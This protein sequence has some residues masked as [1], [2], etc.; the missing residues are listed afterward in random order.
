MMRRLGPLFVVLVAACS[1][2]DPVAPSNEPQA[3]AIVQGNLQIGLYGTTLPVPAKVVVSGASGPLANYPVTFA[4]ESGGSVLVGAST[5]TDANG[6]ATLA[7]WTLGPAPGPNAVRASA[8]TKSVM[9]NATAVTGPPVGFVVVSGDN[10]SGTGGS[11]TPV[12]PVVQVTD[13]NFGVPGVTVTFAVTAGGGSVTPQSVITDA[14]GNAATV[15]RMGAAGG[16]NTLVAST[17]SFP[18]LTLN[19][20][21]V[22]LILTSVV[23]VAGDNRSA[24][25]NNF[26]DTL[27]VVEVRD[28]FDV[29]AEGQTVTFAVTGG[30]GNVAFATA[31]TDVNGRASPGAWRFGGS[32]PQTLSANVASLAPV[33][34][35]G[36]ATPVPAGT[37]NID[38]R[39]LSPLPT[40]DQQA[41]FIAAKTRWQ[42]LIIGDL[43]DFPG[44]I[45][46]NG[47]GA[48]GGADN[49]PA[50]PAVTGPID[51]IVIFA[52]IQDIDGSRGVLAQAGPC[53]VRTS[54]GLTIMGIM[55]F[56]KSDLS[57]LGAGLG[58]VATHEMA[59]V[60][61]FG[62]LAP[63]DASLSNRGGPDPFFTGQAAREA[64][65]AAQ[66][67]ANP[68]TGNA[69]PV[70]N[71][72]GSGTR[73]GHWR[74]TEFRNELM[75]GFYN[76]A[77]NPLS[78]VTAAAM[79]DLGY[80]VD[81]SPTDPFMLAARIGGLRA[82]APT[83]LRLQESLAPW[84]I[85]R[86]DDATGVLEPRR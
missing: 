2:G 74:E 12:P 76:A 63:W 13:G 44:N 3:V 41:A 57:L 73:D 40:A 11:R 28:Q 86:V 45:G 34:F 6:V 67:P 61:G 15:W 56:D 16:T 59:H 35:N 83:G 7:Q 72:G 46:K 24:F 49:T 29:G 66:N 31:T 23:K 53:L 54:N 8:G 5:T 82:G 43:P 4:V 25:A 48:P 51:D 77:P 14:N 58:D 19:A 79:R 9:L 84:P 85:Q 27:P 38:L 50:L 18:T 52:G 22:P 60:L 80:V 36:T 32:G 37:F 55:V 62:T 47:C 30:G 71:T 20:N 69:V 39:F 17:P 10:Q 81:D 1:G 75:T 42:Q 33:T 64:F 68:F 21:A 78:A 70:E 26:T 65:S